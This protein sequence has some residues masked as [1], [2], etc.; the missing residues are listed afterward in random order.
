VG[1][2]VPLLLPIG[3]G[4]IYVTQRADASTGQRA[5]FGIGLIV[6]ALAVGPPLDVA[7]DHSLTAHMTQ[8]VLLLT[9]VPPL[10]VVGAPFVARTWW[11]GAAI[12]TALQTVVMWSWHVPAAYAAASGR[13][14]VH[15]LEHLSFLAVGV[16]FWAT[17]L[18][19]RVGIGAP[20]LL[21]IAA[22]PGTALGVALTLAAGAWYP[23]YPDLGSQQLAGVVMWAGGGTAYLIGAAVLAARAL[24]AEDLAGALT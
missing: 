21:F 19:R 5:A 7:A 8:H 24:R 2:L 22:L 16:A 1:D 11:R 18:S 23:A 10:L 13:S 17:V 14:P 12:A 15:A 9:V 6:L 20:L 3:L 4:A